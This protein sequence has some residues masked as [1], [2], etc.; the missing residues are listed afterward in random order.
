ML[1]FTTLLHYQQEVGDSPIPSFTVEVAVPIWETVKNLYKRKL[2]L[3]AMYVCTKSVRTYIAKTLKRTIHAIL[4]GTKLTQARAY[5]NDHLI[6]VWLVL[7]ILS[8]TTFI[9]EF[10][11]PIQKKGVCTMPVTN[12]IELPKRRAILE[13]TTI[14]YY[15]ICQ[16]QGAGDIEHRGP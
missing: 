1:C 12:M 16:V 11:P 13:P 8:S 9:V 3:F 10:Y 2:G 5:Q 4:Y 14:R 6:L 15:A 7:D